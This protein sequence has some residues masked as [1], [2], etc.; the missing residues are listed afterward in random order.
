MPPG[1]LYNLETDPDETI[2]L[3]SKYPEIVTKLKGQFEVFKKSGRS[4]QLYK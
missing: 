4:V 3:Y 1:Q 2:N